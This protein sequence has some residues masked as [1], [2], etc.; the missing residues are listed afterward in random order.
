MP[1]GRTAGRVSAALSE[2]KVK[3]KV[4]LDLR[5]SACSLA[6]GRRGGNLA[7][8]CIA[9]IL[10]AHQVRARYLDGAQRR[11]LV[12]LRVRVKIEG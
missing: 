10:V 3:T 11:R 1:T 5:S 6:R 7:L 8:L 2:N 4:D 9:V 12:R